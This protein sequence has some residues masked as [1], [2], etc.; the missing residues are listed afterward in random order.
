MHG[1]FA[2]CIGVQD[3]AVAWETTGLVTVVIAGARGRSAGTHLGH[4]GLEAYKYDAWV[5]KANGHAV[6]NAFGRRKR[7]AMQ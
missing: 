6:E 4:L 2:N 1:D 3:A 7:E 5:C